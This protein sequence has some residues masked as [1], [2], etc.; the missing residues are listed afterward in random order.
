[1][2]SKKHSLLIS[3]IVPVYKVEKE[4]D[5]CIKSILCQT[6]ANFELILVDDGSPDSC[7]SK[8]DFWAMNDARIKVLHTANQG[9]SAAR[10]T[11][12]VNASG[13]L[14]AFVDSDDY[15]DAFFLEKLFDAMMSNDADIACCGI[16]KENGLTGENKNVTPFNSNFCSFSQEMLRD[17]SFYE[18]QYVVAWNKL[19]RKE[20]WSNISY[21][22]GRY[23][24]DE[25]VYH[26][27]LMCTEKIAFICDPLYHYVQR[28]GSIMMT[29][30]FGRVSDIIHAMN[31]RIS[32]L[33]GMKGCE[34]VLISA[35]ERMAGEYSTYVGSDH[36]AIS[37]S[38]KELGSLCRDASW[39]IPIHRISLKKKINVLGFRI[40]PY[41]YARVRSY[42]KS[43]LKRGLRTFSWR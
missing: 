6:Y 15:V 26:R 1:M 13:E 38:V 11:G 5:R 25:F 34:G 16:K 4:L 10:N 30:S 18:W 33:K 40:S 29:S 8:C 28:G 21:P 2:D 22:V 3:V 12:I 19:Y 42:I 9:L 41:L 17:V 24:E 31:E 7:P 37:A 32:L 39:V 27:L 23:H 36:R 20:I 35:Y 43:F 14:I